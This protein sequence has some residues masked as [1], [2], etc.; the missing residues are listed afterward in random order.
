MSLRFQYNKTSLHQLNKQL[1]IRLKALPTLKNKE[2][3]LR[4]EV[5]RSKNKFAE[6]EKKLEKLISGEDENMRMWNEFDPGLVREEKVTLSYKMIAGIKTPELDTLTFHV[7]DFFIF[8]SPK[9]YLDGIQVLKTLITLVIEKE[10]VKKKVEMLEY[11]RK[12]TTQKVNLY[13]KV[14]I[15]AHKDA[16]LKIKRFLEDEDNLAK[17]SQKIVKNRQQQAEEAALV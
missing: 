17:A 3:A 8:G 6:L 13:E 1:L 2:S 11:A 7:K 12:K 9:W 14:Q 16:I 5:K 15:P 10:I 4:V